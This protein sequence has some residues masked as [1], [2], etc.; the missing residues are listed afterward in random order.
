MDYHLLK[1]VKKFDEFYK[2]DKSIRKNWERFQMGGLNV[3]SVRDEIIHSWN[4]S[5]QNGINPFERTK[6]PSMVLHLLNEKRDKNRIL[7]DAAVPIL[8]DFF[9]RNSDLVWDLV[10]PE[11]TVLETIANSRYMQEAENINC[12][13][14][15]NFSEASIGTNATG[16]ALMEKKTIQVFAA[17]HFVQELQPYV[18]TA[19]PIR[20][21]FT[22]QLVGILHMTSDKNVVLAHDISLI[23]MKKNQIEHGI[24][25]RIVDENIFIFKNLFESIQEPY[26]LFDNK[27]T[28]LRCNEA[29]QYV[30][31]AQVGRSLFDVLGISSIENKWD[32]NLLL[33]MQE[34]LRMKDGSEWKIEFLPY[35]REGT[36]QGGMAIFQKN[37]SIQPIINKP[38][39]PTRYEF[40]DILTQE[41]SMYKVLQLSKKAAF[42]EKTILLIGESGT[43][44]ELFAQSIHAYGP[45]NTKPFVEVNCGAI[46]K[47]LIASE[48]FGYEGGAFTGAKSKGHKGKFLL[49]DQ[50]TIFLDEIGDLPLEVQVYLLRVLEER[51]VL[52]IGGDRPI[53]IDVRVIAATHKDLELEVKEGRFREDL[54]HRLNVIPIRIP[55]L[56]ERK[57]DIPQLTRFFLDQ[58]KEGLEPQ[59]LEPEV[60]EVLLRYP[61]PGNVRQLKNMIQRMIFTSNGLSIRMDDLPN[62]LELERNRSD[63]EFTP[64]QLNNNNQCESTNYLKN[65]IDKDLLIQTLKET[66]GN[67]SETARILQTSRVTIYKKIKKYQLS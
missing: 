21:P 25:T 15:Q 32:K 50:G 38:K 5:K 43:G 51:T 29:A 64:A 37:R 48:L 27:G 41:P 2:I 13:P 1:S 65:Q 55:A 58:Y 49:A 22:G 47:E 14:G 61:W 19:S 36:V 34:L 59:K 31:L 42:S 54:F 11:G 33:G 45:N 9:Q 23:E 17:E 26:I 67:I 60:M 52:P 40:S 6:S 7:L 30:L 62:E 35:K 46:P 56:R 28:I 44:K 4:R 63:K 16:I 8:Q 20:D 24:G 12:V 10:D 57:G 66:N 3:E 39:K 18:D 53:R